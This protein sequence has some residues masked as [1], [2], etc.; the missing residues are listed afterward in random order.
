MPP[1]IKQLFPRGTSVKYT[2]GSKFYVK[3]ENIYCELGGYE[4]N[5]TLSCT[6]SG[7]RTYLNGARKNYSE[8]RFC[9]RTV[10]GK[11]ANPK[12]WWANPNPNSFVCRAARKFG[13]Y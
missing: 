9:R 12:D 6:A 8:E 7:V 1:I 4:E 3:A 10:N 2:D 13:K 11:E 5:R